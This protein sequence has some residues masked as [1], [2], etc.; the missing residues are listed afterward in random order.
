MNTAD[1]CLWAHGPFKLQSV[2]I[3]RKFFSCFDIRLWLSGP[4]TRTF[5]G[6]INHP[7]RGEQEELIMV[8]VL[9]ET[10]PSVIIRQN[11]ESEAL[12]L[13]TYNHPNVQGF[14]GVCVIGNPLCLVFEYSDYRNLNHYLQRSDTNRS[15][16]NALKL[17]S[18]D[19]VYMAKQIAAGMEYLTEKDHIHKQL[20][21]KNCLVGCNALDVKISSIGISWSYP[22]TSY[23]FLDSTDREQYPVRWYPPET[24]QYG[25]F[26]EDTDIWSFGVLLWELHSF[27]LEPYYGMSNDEVI[28][29]VREGDVLPCPKDCHQ[30][31]YMLMRECWN[32]IPN[33]RPRFSV[34]HQRISTIYSPIPV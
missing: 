14:L 11:F 28:S 34:L 12:A 1:L 17:S 6:H 23:Y 10:N 13:T 5:L 27:G 31:V 20:C 19:L 22:S 18:L 2:C 32:L 25:A 33:D 16:D 30:D 7:T 24:I 4:I 29:L 26:S 15:D 3:A 21:T 8:K 9:K